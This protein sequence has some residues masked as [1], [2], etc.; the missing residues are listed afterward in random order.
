MD[1]DAPGTAQRPAPWRAGIALVLVLLVI[2]TVVA[3]WNTARSIRATQQQ[4]LE[5]EAARIDTAVWER[6]HAYEQ[7]LL[8]ASGL[9]LGSDVVT[10]ADWIDY[11]AALDLD[12]RYPGFLS[13]S[14]MPV[15]P[16]AELPAFVAAVR[17]ERLLPD[18]VGAAD[19][20]GFT[21]HPP[22]GVAP[23]AQPIAAPVLYVAPTTPQNQESLGLDPMQET[24]LRDALELSD[25]TDRPVVSSRVRL[26]GDPSDGRVGFVAFLPMKKDGVPIGWLSAAFLAEQFMAGL[27]G[28]VDLPISFE[29]DD[30]AGNLLYSTCGLAEDGSPRRLAERDGLTLE[31]RPALSGTN[32][33]IRY[34]TTEGFETTTEEIAPSFVAVGGLIVTLLVYVVA[35]TG[36]GWRRR[37][38]SLQRSETAVRYLATHDPLTGLPNRALFLERLENAAASGALFALAYVDIDGFKQVNDSY[39]HRVGDKRILFTHLAVP[40]MTRLRQPERMVL[41]TLV[42]AGVARSRSDALAWT[43]KLAGEHAQEWL[44]ELRD[45]MR[46]VDDLR[47]EGPNL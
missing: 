30:N 31:T 42:D 26:I 40:V 46:K 22:N 1:Q 23:N 10:R 44:A 2:A 12:E 36:A 35:T 8:G 33:H 6:L 5:M 11:V 3:T 41:D 18:Q 47:S 14:Y 25:R 24:T 38:M 19:I 7:V 32:W 4:R 45:A 16:N 29:I 15:V 20:A 37:A 27:L 34:S 9:F 21:V 28:D 17:S 43:V 13:L 39:G